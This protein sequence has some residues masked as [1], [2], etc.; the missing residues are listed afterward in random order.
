MTYMV[1]FFIT[2]AFNYLFEKVFKTLVFFENLKTKK[3]TLFYFFI[4]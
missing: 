3:R 2:V 1:K 4:I